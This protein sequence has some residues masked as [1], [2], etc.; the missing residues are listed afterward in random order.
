MCCF[1]W[2]SRHRANSKAEIEI[3]LIRQLTEGNFPVIPVL[4]PG[5]NKSNLSRFL[6]RNTWVDFR[7]G[8][9]NIEALQ[10]LIAAIKGDE[11]ILKN[12]SI[13][14]IYPST[15]DSSRKPDIILPDVTFEDIKK[16]YLER[17]T[18]Y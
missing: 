12:L 3:A 7:D 6:A 11:Q 10:M 8:I 16:H 18:L 1:Y 15:F 5:A 9:D 4:L 17:Q 13:Q 14:E 2:P